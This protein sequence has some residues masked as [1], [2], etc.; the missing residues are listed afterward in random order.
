LSRSQQKIAAWGAIFIVATLITGIL[1]MNFRN[2]P[3]IDWEIG[4]VAIFGFMMLIGIPMFWYFKKRDW[5]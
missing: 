5:I 1:G 4:F 3:G 2:A